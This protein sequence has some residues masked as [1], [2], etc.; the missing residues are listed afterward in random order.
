MSKKIKLVG[1]KR[2][3]H[4][5]ELF[6]Q[7]D[8]VYVMSDERAAYLLNQ[9]DDQTGFPYFEEYQGPEEG[10]NPS[11]P[12][13]DVTKAPRRERSEIRVRKPKIEREGRAPRQAA[14][15]KANAQSGPIE[16]GDAVAV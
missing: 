6:L 15:A 1:C 14:I 5:G 4:K 11:I 16:D 3:N 12:E 10:K 9:T 8:G 7:S 13:A 2:F